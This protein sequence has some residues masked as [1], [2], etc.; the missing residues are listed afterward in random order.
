MRRTWHSTGKVDSDLHSFR[1]AFYALIANILHATQ[2][3][4]TQKR[5]STIVVPQ[6]LNPGILVKKPAKLPD[7]H[8]NT[9]FWDKGNMKD[10]LLTK[11]PNG[12]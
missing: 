4:N 5:Q 9:W 11:V 8:I 12:A 7:G 6:F 3:T 2:Y 10:T 1:G